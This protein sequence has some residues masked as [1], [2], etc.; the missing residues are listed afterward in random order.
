MRT[1]TLVRAPRGTSVDRR[2]PARARHGRLTI[3][4]VRESVV[5]QL[6]RELPPEFAARVTP[7]SLRALIDAELSRWQE[8]RIRDFVPIFVARRIRARLVAHR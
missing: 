5:E 8:S 1:E 2:S 7:E 4:P 3:A 6:V